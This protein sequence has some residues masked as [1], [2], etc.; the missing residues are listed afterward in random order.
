MLGY[1]SLSLSI[2]DEISLP[3]EYPPSLAFEKALEG[4]LI[5]SMSSTVTPPRI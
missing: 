4:I 1:S 5:D 2:S 3:M